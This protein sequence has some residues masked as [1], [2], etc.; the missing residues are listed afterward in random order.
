MLEWTK[1]RG[2][3]LLVSRV[4]GH[5]VPEGARG[6]ALAAPLWREG[7]HR[8]EQQGPQPAS[9]ADRLAQGH[10]LGLRRGRRAAQRGQRDFNCAI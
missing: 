5:L 3:H 2:L 6:A 10:G 8:A 7:G 9:G 1:R 4:V